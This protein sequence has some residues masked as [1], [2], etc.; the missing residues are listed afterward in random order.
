ML[1]KKTILIVDDSRTDRALYRH[2]IEHD[3]ENK[4]QFLEAESIEDGLLMWRSRQPDVLLIDLR[5]VDGSGMQ[6]LKT[7]QQEIYDEQQEKILQNNIFKNVIRKNDDYVGVI[8]KLPVIVIT[9]SDHVRDAVDA[10]QAGAFDYLIKSEVTQSSLL[11][12]IRN[13]YAYLVLNEQLEQSQ[14][15]ELIV[16]RIALKVRQNLILNDIC[17][18]IA[19]EV[20]QFLQANRTVIYKF[21]ADQTR[22]IIAESVIEPVS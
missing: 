16:S 3:S 2:Y 11:Q 18:A 7:M 5:L 15:R 9:G 4:Y 17:Q 14:K 22:K 20:R 13:L 8:P 6:I 1:T 10:M 12:S 19:I 21:N